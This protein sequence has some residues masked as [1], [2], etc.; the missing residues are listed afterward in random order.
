M[1]KKLVL[2][3]IFFILIFDSLSHIYEVQR[4]YLNLNIVHI[5]FL[6]SFRLALISA[7]LYFLINKA[8]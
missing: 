3:I 4:N 5:V 6:I 1:E 2:K 7:L 8:N